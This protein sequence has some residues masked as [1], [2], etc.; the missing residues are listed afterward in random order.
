M[1]AIWAEGSAITASVSNAGPAIA[2]RP[3][4]YALRTMT[5]ILGTVASETAL[6]IFAP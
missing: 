5:E 4:P 3:A 2:Y 6:I 1:T